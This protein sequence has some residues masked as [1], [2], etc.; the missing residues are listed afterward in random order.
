M[1]FFIKKT[2]DVYLGK[3]VHAVLNILQVVPR[4]VSPIEKRG[5][6]DPIFIKAYP[7]ALAHLLL[8]QFKQFDQINAN[9]LYAVSQ[10]KSHFFKNKETSKPEPLIRFPLLSQDREKV[11]V[12]A[13]RKNLFIGRWYDQVVGPKELPLEKLGYQTG[14]CPVA[15]NIC[16][17]ILNLP[18]T[19]SQKEAERVLDIVALEAS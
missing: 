10:Y 16:S 13:K 2:Y 11:I 1:A 4:E 19:V 15:E 14:S 12:T 7:N 18:T 8:N 6:F 5:E 3:V 9:R 17:K